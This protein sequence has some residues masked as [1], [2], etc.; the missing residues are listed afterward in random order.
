MKKIAALLMATTLLLT[1]CVGGQTTDVP[2]DKVKILAPAGATALSLLPL[3]DNKHVK[4]TIVQGPEV[5]SA[6]LAKES[7]DYDVIL[8]PVNLGTKMIQEGNTPFLLDSIITWG[9]LY[10]VGNSAEALNQEGDFASFGEGA[11]PGMILKNTIDFNQVAVK[12][13]AYNAV[14]DVQ[15]QLLSGK[16]NVGLLAEPA[17]TATIMK[18]KEKGINLSVIKDLQAEFKTKHNMENAGYPQA[19]MF[20]KRGRNKSGDYASKRIEK[21]V[22]KTV[23]KDPT[24]I[25]KLA[26]KAGIKKLGIPNE[27]IAKL[28][29]DKQN[30]KYVKASKATKDLE[31]FLKMF[32]ITYTED[33]IIR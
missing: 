15:A 5:L 28:T 16:A 3:Y 22:N 32:K 20:V 9:N 12:N 27:K 14:S 1:G 4:I 25:S 23:K 10:V 21:F 6:E 18:A 13:V 29:W 2:N 24:Q 19:A 11:V 31:T 8:A 33:M 30:I 26:K 17:A 7:S